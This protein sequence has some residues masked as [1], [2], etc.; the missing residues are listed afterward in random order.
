[1]ALQIDY[2]VTNKNEVFGMKV[3][4]VGSTHAGVFAAKEILAQHPEAEVA[5]F[6][7]GRTVSFLSCGIALWVGDHV[8]APEKMF[9]ESPASLT[10]AGVIVHMEH[11]VTAA[12]L[13]EKT[14]RVRDLAHGDERW[15]A[16]DKL[17]FTTGSIPV[18]PNLP[19][20][21][22][23][24]IVL[25]K[26]WEDGQRLKKLAAAANSV[27]VIGAG[28]IGAELAEQLTLAGKEVTLIDGM[29]RMMAK[30]FSAVFTTAIESKYR[31]HGVKLALDQYVTG[32][33]ETSTN[34]TVT[35]TAGAY[36]GDLVVLGMGFQPNTA[37][38]KGQVDMLPNGAIIVD[39]YMQTSVPGVF[40]AGDAAT[41]WSNAIQETIYLPLATNAIRQGQLIGHNLVQPTRKDMGS[42]GT[43]AV[44]LFDQAMVTAGMTPAQA[45][46]AGLDVSEQTLVTSYRPEFMLSTESVL[47]QLTWETDSHRLVGG[48]FMSTHDVSM[49]AN[50]VSL[51]IQQG[52]TLEELAYSDFLF[53]PNFSQPINFI[54]ETALAGLRD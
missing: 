7:K 9:Y 28:Y 37:L 44:S 20:H 45:S 27:I 46:A 32:F 2:F 52:M 49:A 34:I 47:T 16:F 50:V 54:A 29:S 24:R 51:A 53:Q 36:T 22:S 10:E 11:E 21:D 48:T 26:N 12:N 39:R 25:A 19:G 15:M 14:L 33:S 17:V 4:I 6:E 13:A 30:N 8:S 31:S 1:M 23:E 5:I 38:V 41:T 18:Q 3:G 35:T 43:S 42:Q 40:A